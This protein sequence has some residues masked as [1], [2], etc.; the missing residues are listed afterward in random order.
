M[1]VPDD[2]LARLLRDIYRCPAGLGGARL[3]CID[4]PAGSG[5]TTLAAQLVEALPATVV[6]MD[7]LYAGWTGLDAGVDQ[8]LTAVLAP[9]ARGESGAYRRYDWSA[10]EYAETVCVKPTAVLVVEGCGSAST[11]TDAYLPWI[12]WVEAPDDVRLARG[13][14]RDGADA[15]AHWRGFM[16][17][18]RVHYAANGTERRSHVR[19]DGTGRLRAESGT[20]GSNESVESGHPEVRRL[21]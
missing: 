2:V 16:A 15:L 3:V 5:K 10:D 12:I 13:L 6:H 18:E 11:G 9:L 7:D 21:L 8:L 14:A 17:Q 19:L 1:T 4:G 20:P